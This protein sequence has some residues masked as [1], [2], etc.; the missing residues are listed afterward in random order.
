MAKTRKARTQK[1]HSKVL[2]IPELRSSMEHMDNYSH[3]LVLTKSMK[4]G[5]KLFASEWK[6]V[7]GK[8]LSL[9]IAEDYLKNKIKLRKHGKTRRHRG[10]SILTG[11]PLN[12]ITRSGDYIPA[13]TAVYPSLVSKGF[14]NPE[15]A[16]L[17]DGA[18]QKT[19]PYP[20]TGSN[21]AHAGGGILDGASSLASAASFRPFVAQNPITTLQSTGLSWKGLPIGPGPNSYDNPN[22]KT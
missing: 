7:F 21:K 14:W 18:S 20:T 5:A 15:P 6:R 22:L 9:K 3:K 17:H 8:Q 13:P 16:I 11:A 2:T 19:V 10:G 12:H 1:K 4:D